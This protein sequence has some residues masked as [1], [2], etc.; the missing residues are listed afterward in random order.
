[1]LIL[2]G[3][4]IFT[5]N[6][7]RSNRYEVLKKDNERSKYKMKYL[8]KKMEL[9]IHQQWLKRNEA[10]GWPCKIKLYRTFIL[11]WGIKITI[12]WKESHGMNQNKMVHLGSGSH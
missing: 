2:I 11:S 4:C 9:K 8:Q 6:L 10:S 12:S 3:T 1:M 5:L 7:N